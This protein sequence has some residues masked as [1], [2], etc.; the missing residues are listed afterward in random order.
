[1]KNYVVFDL[2][3]PNRTNNS[4][5]S[6]ALLIVKNN[7]VVKSIS[8]L[9]NPESYFE[10]FNINLTSITPEDVENAPTFKEYWPKIS[11]Y[12][13]SNMVVGHNVQFDLRTVSRVLNHYDMEIPEFDYCC[14]LFLSRKHFNLNSYK[15][16]NV[17]KHIKFDYN[18]HI[19]IEDAKASYEILEYINKENEIDPNDCRHYHYRLKFEKTYDEYL[20][21]NLNEL[22]GMLY[23]L[24]Y[25]KSISPSQIELLKKWHEENKSY[26][27]TTVFNNL[28]KMFDSIFHK[29]VVTPMDIKFL[30]TRTPPVLTSIIYSA[31]TLHL[32]ILRG[33]AE[34]IMSDNYVDEY[35]LNILYD[36]LL[37]G[38]ILKGNYIYDNILQI[39]KS[40]LD[41]DAVDYNPQNELFELFD[42]FLIINSNREGDFDFENKTYCLTGEFEHGTKDDIEYV[43]DG[44]GLV[45]K[46]SLSYDVNYLFVGN[47]GNPSW[48]KGKM[49]EKIFEAKKLIEKNSNLIIIGEELLFD[50]LD[51]L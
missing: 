27:D 37:E 24:R 50:K 7:K 4:I 28:N 26:D 25:Y 23:L 20:A 15:L 3:T 1:M 12:L 35:T 45:R 19:A 22:Y 16:T 14:T 13:T 32:Q 6:V 51:I 40:S 39:I 8:Q 2:E 49:G 9:I 34:V 42:N 29:K 5:S 10:Q 33:M 31:K 11:D 21:T 30:L 44:Y 36:W 43:L 47:L 48:K 38:N 18:P 41:G 46:N 17:S